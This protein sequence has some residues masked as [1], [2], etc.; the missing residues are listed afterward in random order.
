MRRVSTQFGSARASD[1]VSILGRSPE[2]DHFRLQRR[3][4]LPGHAHALYI[5]PRSED[6]CTATSQHEDACLTTQQSTGTN[7]AKYGYETEE[8][9]VDPEVA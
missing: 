2:D 1:R 3:G 8:K 9:G 7:R 6:R 4:P 5:A